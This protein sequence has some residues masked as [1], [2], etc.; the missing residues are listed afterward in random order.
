MENLV[1]TD[2]HSRYEVDL[3]KRLFDFSVKT[4]RFL[5]TLPYKKEYDVFRY[6]LSKSATSIGANYEEAQTS[7]QKE[8]IQKVRIALREANETNY[9]LRLLDELNAG[10][11]EDCKQL[12]KESKEIALIL[13]SILVKIEKRLNQNNG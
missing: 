7:T 2:V 8:F 10:I 4:I 13:G 12:I 3:R 5:G 11:S 6:Q 1:L 9:W